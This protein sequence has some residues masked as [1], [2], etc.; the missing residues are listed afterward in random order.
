MYN[1][2]WVDIPI[3][4]Y[5]SNIVVDLQNLQVFVGYEYFY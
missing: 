5:I 4:L 3:H 1:G 2:L